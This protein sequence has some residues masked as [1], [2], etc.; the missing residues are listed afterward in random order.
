MISVLLA[1]LAVMSACVLTP[2]ED[3]DDRARHRYY[4]ED[5]WHD[6]G[7]RDPHCR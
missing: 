4:Q 5:A 3:Y 1:L 7:K 6:C 2:R